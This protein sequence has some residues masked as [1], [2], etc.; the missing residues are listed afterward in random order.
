MRPLRY[1]VPLAVAATLVTGCGNG[2][3]TTPGS[4]SLGGVNPVPVDNGVA[5]LSADEILAKAKTALSKAKSVHVTGSNSAAGEEFQLDLRVK[6]SEG[7][8]GTIL[9]GE[10]KIELIRIGQDVY[11]KATGALMNSL[12][13]SAEAAKLLVGKYLKGSATDPKFK[14]LASFADLSTMGTTFLDPDGKITK[15]ER[16]TIRGIPAIGLVDPSADGGTL[17]IALQGEP[18]PLQITPSATSKDKGSLDFL[19]YGKPVELT[20]PPAA[21]VVDIA[22]LGGN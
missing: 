6:G 13:G 21:Q 7:G 11:F 17:Y 19:D 20:A 9:T 16:K 12:A 14:E 1:L 3:S 15:G 2:T 4:G 18:L 5:N 22:K 8:A 10:D